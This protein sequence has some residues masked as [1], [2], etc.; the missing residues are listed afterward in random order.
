MFDIIPNT[1][2]L[3]LT[4]LLPIYAAHKALSNP[5]STLT[6]STLAPWLTYFLLLSITNLIDPFISV[7]PFAAYLRLFLR[8]WL[9][10]PGESQGASFAYAAY[11]RPFLHQH[12]RDIETFIN[13]AHDTVK[14]LGARWIRL[15]IEWIRT[16]LLGQT[17]A[18]AQARQQAAEVKKDV[19]YAQRLLELF[20]GAQAASTSTHTGIAANS[21]RSSTTAA[22]SLGNALQ[23]ATAAL[24][25]AAVSSTSPPWSSTPQAPPSAPNKST[26]ADA[27][28][29]LIP[30]HL[31]TLADRLGYVSAQKERLRTL[32]SAFEREEASAMSASL[33]APETSALKKSGSEADFDKISHE[34]VS[35]V[36]GEKAAQAQNGWGA[37]MWGRKEA[38]VGKEKEK[39]DAA[40]EEAEKAKDQ[41][42]GGSSSAV[43]I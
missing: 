25:Y 32:L 35:A 37:W 36:V 19:P 16:Q 14:A 6:P 17:A 20:N 38:G 2:S 13:E 33:V 42:G 27:A 23:Q 15:A 28:A 12:E 8:L 30:P 7:L 34:E 21:G 39:V 22:A 3:L 18:Q 4:T 43:E 10:L 41:R 24:S 1:L 11:V 40:E 29:A 26:L 31:S 5:A 9:L